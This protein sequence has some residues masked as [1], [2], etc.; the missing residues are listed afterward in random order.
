MEREQRIGWL[1]I[2]LCR[3]VEPLVEVES[4]PNSE[5]AVDVAVREEL[6]RLLVQN[7]QR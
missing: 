3:A 1:G 2:G 5:L 4:L 6:G 7:G